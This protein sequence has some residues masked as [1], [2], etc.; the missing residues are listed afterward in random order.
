MD[1]V[2]QTKN[3]LPVFDLDMED[4]LLTVEDVP[5]PIINEENVHSSTL[6]DL[7]LWLKFHGVTQT[8][9]NKDSLV[10]K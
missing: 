1:A 2:G 3:V 8:G 6:K 5:C 4:P 9:R 10:S 7:W